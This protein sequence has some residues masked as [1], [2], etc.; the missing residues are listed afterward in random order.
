MANRLLYI[1]VLLLCTLQLSAQQSADSWKDS[2]WYSV[3]LPGSISGKNIFEYNRLRYAVLYL[4]YDDLKTACLEQIKAGKKEFDDLQLL[5]DSAVNNKDTVRIQ[6]TSYEL[7]WL[8][9]EFLRKGETR[10]FGTGLKKFIDSV[11]YRF[12]KYGPDA[13]RFYYLPDKRPFF[14]VMEFSGIIEDNSDLMKTL[15]KNPGEYKKLNDRLR[16]IWKKS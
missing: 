9:S 1:F 14:G 8:V 16:T 3:K 5:F 15:G 12:E 11:S 6:E 2:S 10:V 13:W 7:D 4:S